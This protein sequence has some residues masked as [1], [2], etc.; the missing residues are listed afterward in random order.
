M[1]RQRGMVLFVC[2]VLTLLM[3]VLAASALN[4]ALLETRLVGHLLS[5]AQAFEQAEATLLEAASTL[6]RP[7]VECPACLP[8]TRP[9]ALEGPWQRG[10]HG[11]FTVQNLGLSE[12][13][14]H[15]P[16]GEPVRLFRITA[17]S[18]QP[19]ARQVLEAVYAVSLDRPD[20]PQRILWRHRAQEG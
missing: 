1:K 5:R 9:H 13:A 10:R 2:L 14:V 12:R 18:A 20:P 16:A 6:H 3:S 4:D 11:F 19:A 17:V 8:P 15:M 7:R